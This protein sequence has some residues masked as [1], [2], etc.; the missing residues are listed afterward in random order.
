MQL[1]ATG[2]WSKANKRWTM[3][4]ALRRPA[5]TPPKSTAPSSQRPIRPKE[6]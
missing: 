1:I 3:L 6:R 2:K 5:S 4:V